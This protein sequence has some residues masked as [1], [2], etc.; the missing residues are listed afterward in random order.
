MGTAEKDRAGFRC[1]VAKGNDLIK[2]LIGEFVK[3]LG[4]LVGDVNLQFVHCVYR[5]GVNCGRFCT[6]GEG[7][8]PPS[9][10]VIDQSLSH[11]AAGAVMGADE[12]DSFHD[13]QLPL[14]CGVGTK[15]PCSPVPVAGFMLC[16]FP[17]NLKPE[18]TNLKPLFRA[19]K[20]NGKLL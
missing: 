20:L 6:G 11:L 9:K 4:P 10:V 19:C 18:T 1:L 2:L 8:H 17:S 7:L 12:E 15:I 14:F 13:H 16:A 3:A 5:Q